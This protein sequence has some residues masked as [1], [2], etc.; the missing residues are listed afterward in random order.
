MNGGMG[1][2][3][4]HVC[5]LVCMTR[6]SLSAPGEGPRPSAQ[7]PRG[8]GPP[9]LFLGQGQTKEEGRSVL[10]ILDD[11]SVCGTERS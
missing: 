2:R 4:G 6:M 3:V 9:V 1:A 11:R 7:R 10:W 5:A 8:S